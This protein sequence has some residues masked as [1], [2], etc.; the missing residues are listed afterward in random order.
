[1]IRQ[2]SVSGNV[3]IEQINI[4][5]SKDF[6]YYYTYNKQNLICSDDA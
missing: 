4:F 3:Q 5:Q 6:Y 2:I 1:M